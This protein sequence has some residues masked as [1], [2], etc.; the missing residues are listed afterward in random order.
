MEPTKSPE[1]VICPSARLVEKDI[2]LD[3]MEINQKNCY[4]ICQA[5][6]GDSPQ[7]KYDEKP[8]KKCNL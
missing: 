7:S 3:D 5:D 6:D 1:S 2:F 8:Y 4:S